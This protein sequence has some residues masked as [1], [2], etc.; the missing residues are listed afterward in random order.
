MMDPYSSW[1]PK[2][3]AQWSQ[4]PRDLNSEQEHEQEINLGWSKPLC[5]GGI[6]YFIPT[7]I[8][9]NNVLSPY[10]LWILLATNHG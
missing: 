10:V 2:W 9:L 7:N 8:T 5:V 1:V 4:A 3:L 6:D